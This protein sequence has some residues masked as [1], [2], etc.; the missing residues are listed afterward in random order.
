MNCLKFFQKVPL[1]LEESW[2]FFS[3]PANLKILTPDR[4]RFEIKGENE[5]C[6]MY[7]GQIIAYTI[8]PF[9]NLPLEW[10][11]EITHVEK[12]Y[13]F[14]DE[15]RFGPYKFW[16]H[17]HRFNPIPN[18][19]EMVDTIYYKLPFGI[20]GKL[21]NSLKV[22]SDLEEIFAYRREKMEKL[23]GIYSETSF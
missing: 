6:Q 15:Q 5:N 21:I 22:K 23:F 9:L 20:L 4:L 10:V 8:H 16:H 3:S 11:T 18:G 17:E 14:I 12:P 7:S 1:S 19:V 13:Y 2:D